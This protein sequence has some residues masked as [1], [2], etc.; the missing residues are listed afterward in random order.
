MLVW[1]MLGSP[2]SEDLGLIGILRGCIDER[3]TSPTNRGLVL[4]AQIETRLDLIAKREW[5][6][7]AVR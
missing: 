2:K 5:E 3:Q 6:A 4:H 7:S 1:T